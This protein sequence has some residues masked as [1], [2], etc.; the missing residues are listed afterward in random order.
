MVCFVGFD[1]KDVGDTSQRLDENP[2]KLLLGKEEPQR[3]V[4]VVH[5][6][7][8]SSGHVEVG[9]VNPGP[10][11]DMSDERQNRRRFLSVLSSPFRALRSRTPSPNNAVQAGASA[12]SASMQ[13]RS[14]PESRASSTLPRVDHSQ[15]VNESP[16]QRLDQNIPNPQR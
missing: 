10:N 3:T 5:N 11:H 8:I 13:S 15:T 12:S 16:N 7:I 4:K 14:T 1:L 2:P 6:I 9:N